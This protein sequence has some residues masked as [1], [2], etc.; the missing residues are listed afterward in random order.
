[1]TKWL[2]RCF[3]LLN[4]I[5]VK[6]KQPP[7]TEVDSQTEQVVGV[8]PEHLQKWYGLEMFLRAN[9][10]RQLGNSISALGTNFMSLPLE[11]FEEKRAV[12]GDELHATIHELKAVQDIFEISVLFEVTNKKHFVIR[13][14]WQVV[15]AREN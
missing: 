11:D 12:L 1:M 2:D 7:D 13:K 10:V 6:F 15:V 4:D 14:A 3:A 5:P 8:L 9:M